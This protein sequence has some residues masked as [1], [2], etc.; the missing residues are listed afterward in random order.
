MT[1]ELPKILQIWGLN[2]KIALTPNS[3]IL[4][5]CVSIGEQPDCIANCKGGKLPIKGCPL[6]GKRIVE[7][8]EKF[9]DIEKL[10]TSAE[11]F[12]KQLKCATCVPINIRRIIRIFKGGTSDN[13]K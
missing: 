13:N 7:H 12:D 8:L 5:N 3:T 11:E 10:Y 4:T 2:V 9:P 6:T 1:A